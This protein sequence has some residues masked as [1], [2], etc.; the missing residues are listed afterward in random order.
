M[1]IY[2]IYH[3]IYDN[4]A[5]ITGDFVPLPN[6]IDENPILLAS[7]FSVIKKYERR[8]PMRRFLLTSLFS[9]S[10]F[11]LALGIPAWEASAPVTNSSDFMAVAPHPL[12]PSRL[13]AASANQIF[14]SQADG[15]WKRVWQTED[16][17]QTIREI[18]AFRETPGSLFVLT[19]KGPFQMNLL[20]P[21]ENPSRIRALPE[22]AR[23]L[24]FAVVPG[25][26]DH[27]LLGTEE[28]I[29]E[30]DDAGKSWYPLH[31][32]LDQDHF[33]MIHFMETKLFVATR[34]TLFLS[35]DFISFRPVFSLHSPALFSDELPPPPESEE[36]SDFESPGI[37]SPLTDLVM[38]A[39]QT[40][41]WLGTTKGVFESRDGG[42]SWQALPSSGLQ[43]IHIRHLSYAQKSKQ[44]FAATPSGLYQYE[45][46]DKHWKILDQGL[47]YAA[48]RDLAVQEETHHLVT[49]TPEGIRRIPFAFP[50]WPPPEI[51]IPSPDHAGLW[52]LLLRLEPTAQEI[53][54]ALIR[55]TNLG[56]GK[57]KRW[58]AES[59]LRALMPD[60]SFGRDFSSDNNTDIDRGATN[61]P[62]IYIE[63]PPNIAQ[64]WDLNVSWDLGD[65]I[66]G[67][68]QTSIDSREKLMVELRQDLVSEATR[69]YY[70]RRRLQMDL[71]FSEAL[72]ERDHL[73]KLIRMDELTA[74]LDGMT[75][76][77]FSRQLEAVYE[78][79]PELNHLWEYQRATA[80]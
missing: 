38:S 35:S 74:I 16:S 3:K 80:K 21:H 13:I 36:N 44:L 78:R 71:V 67:S 56:H 58:Q 75:Q 18:S 15:P 46:P 39:E 26:R 69:I 72:S 40:L 47:A 62:D 29:F 53:Q 43:D 31:A 4:Y 61:T 5:I 55:Y 28:N 1:R 66:W 57:I 60:V 10:V 7:L 37:V 42:L 25:D 63:G 51:W 33:S 8:P 59:R 73:E 27:W 54:K 41:L 79:H 77:S 6:T 64:G 22:N 32:L 34:K 48:L 2:H 65:L 14:E 50:E 24:S 17:Q 20:A 45:T 70:E 11:P 68:N 9:F 76:G 52:H 23:V 19:E 12:D 30:T 49:A